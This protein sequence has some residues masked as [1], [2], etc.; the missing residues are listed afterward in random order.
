M[1]RS[2]RLS[3]WST[4][5]S[6]VINYANLRLRKTRES[7]I[8]ET[9]QWTYVGHWGPFTMTG[10]PCG[11]HICYCRCVMARLYRWQ[12]DADTPG[13][14]IGHQWHIRPSH[15]LKQTQSTLWC[16]WLVI[17][18]NNDFNFLEA[19][20]IFSVKL[21]L[22]RDSFLRKSFRLW[23]ELEELSGGG[24]FAPEPFKLFPIWNHTILHPLGT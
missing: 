6:L 13:P 18:T 24:R 1:L 10:P 11:H 5:V 22:I 16:K 2:W 4:R 17:T 8:N 9:P 14:L 15:W 19:P 21:F 7:D 12:Y 3:C 20:Q 23:W